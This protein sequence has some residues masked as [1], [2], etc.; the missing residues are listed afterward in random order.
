MQHRPLSAM[1]HPRKLRGFLQSLVEQNIEMLMGQ[2]VGGDH[3]EPRWN[4]RGMH[5]EAWEQAKK[6]WSGVITV[7]NALLL[8]NFN[9]I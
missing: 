4:W 5:P 6:D 9:A 8:Q 2:I 3:W 7:K 1:T